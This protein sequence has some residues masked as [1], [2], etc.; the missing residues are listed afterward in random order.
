MKFNKFLFGAAA[1][2]MGVFASCSS[3]EPVKGP[4]GGNGAIEGEQYMAI[5]ITT[6]GLGGSRAAGV[7][8]PEFEAG[9]GTECD[10]TA[11]NTYF[12][13]Y[14]A[15]GN[16]FP[17]AAANVNGTVATN[18][19]KPT[20]I[21]LQHGP[22]DAA[23][24]EGVL[25]LGKAIGEG[26]VGTTPAQVLCVA[27]PSKAFS[28]AEYENKNLSWVLGKESSTPATLP[29]ETGFVMTSTTYV[30]GVKIVTAQDVTGKFAETPEAA[31]TN[32]AVLY[33]ERLA[34][35]VRAKGLGEY[36]AQIRKKVTAEDGAVST[37][38][39]E[40]GKITIDNK[41]AI[42]KVELL[43]WELIKTAGQSNAFKSLKSEWLATDPF[44]GW[45]DAD[46]HRSYWAAS[47]A[48]TIRNT[49]IPSLSDNSKYTKGNF[50]SGVENVA[51][52]YENTGYAEAPNT[53]TSVNDRNTAYNATS[54][55]V[56]AV[57]KTYDA[58]T[59]TSK[60]VDLMRWAGSYYTVD[61]LKELV[62]TDYNASVTGAGAKATANDVEF[63]DNS[64]L[65]NTY[66]AVVTVGENRTEMA[67]FMSILWWKNGITSYYA[68][69]EHLGQKFGVVRNH[70]YEYEFDGVIG[71]GVP[72]T[73]PNTP[74]ETETFLSAKLYCLNWHVVSNKLTLE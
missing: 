70:I 17:L 18:M 47:N 69:I 46:K 41:E 16:A 52:C 1:L 53:P 60:P 35:K 20:K 33:I 62:A 51:Y 59:Q 32:P 73:E 44:N 26:Y 28:V 63:V 74:E 72:G 21:E 5:S 4:D 12:F 2:S 45:N 19:V 15:N 50:V 14:D 61:H 54:V 37:V 3:D 8:D 42:V 57:V 40:D 58:E 49:D 36:T 9:V 25:V 24:L 11:E 31:K 48:G 67:N 29:A 56:K 65:D 38:V 43:G 68:N 71:L 27:N 66:H 7:G 39:T 55:V 64:A 10:I 6:A 13:F 22:G 23:T 30:D 34:A